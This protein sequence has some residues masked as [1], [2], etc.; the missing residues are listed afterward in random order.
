MAVTSFAVPGQITADA[1]F[2]AWGQAISNALAAIGLVKAADTGQI[3]WTTV[4][5]PAG[6]SVVSGYEIWRFNDALQATAPVFF[7]IEYGSGAGTPWHSLWITVGTASDGI[8][9]LSGAQIGTRKQIGPSNVLP[10]ATVYL[11]GATDRVGF[12]ML[13]GTSNGYG[14][15]IE[16]SKDASGNNTSTGICTYIHSAYSSYTNQEQFVPSIGVPPQ[17][18]TQAYAF[19]APGVTAVAG[20]DVGL[21]PHFIYFG[22]LLNPRL[23]LITYMNSDIQP[24]IQIGVNMYGSLRNY[25]TLGQNVAYT[26]SNMGPGRG[27]GSGNVALMMRY[28]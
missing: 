2:R 13:L 26:S 27:Q 17:V 3:N 25:L 22:K 9:N 5:K 7:K 21:F 4:I 19:C 23:G 14:F 15:S 28:E 10:G 12:V 16:R 18:D 11:S 24:F 20:T 8:G 1:D 6:S